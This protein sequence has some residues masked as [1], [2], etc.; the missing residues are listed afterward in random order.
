MV[1]INILYMSDKNRQTRNILGRKKTVVTWGNL[2]TRKTDVRKVTGVL[3]IYHSFT[4][5]NLGICSG[6]AKFE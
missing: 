1:L 5:L 6:F 2:M 4:K 3:K